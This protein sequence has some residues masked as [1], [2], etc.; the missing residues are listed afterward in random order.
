MMHHNRYSEGLLLRLRD[1]RLANLQGTLAEARRDLRATLGDEEI[2]LLFDNWLNAN[3][4]RIE[5]KELKVGEVVAAIRPRRFVDPDQR[6]RE[7]VIAN[8]AVTKLKSNMFEEFTA[9]IWDTVL[10]N[11]VTLRNAIGKDMAHA[12]GW[13]SQLA[14]VMKPTE[15][16]AK[17]FSTKQLF[18]LS[19]RDI[20]ERLT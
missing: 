5:I 18:D 6:R 13:Y 15:S 14:K 19:R 7:D 12:G 3:F 20:F 17:K 8:R 4:D 2:D 11:G 9:R 10:P 16:V 1:W